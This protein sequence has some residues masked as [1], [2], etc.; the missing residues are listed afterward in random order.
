MHK[1]SV[2]IPVYQVEKYIRETVNSVLD[3]SY[4]NL[5]VILVDDGSFDGS[6]LICDEFEKK[7]DRVKVIHKENGGLSDARNA[8][9]KCA[10]GDFVLF[11]DG[12]DYWDDPYAIEKLVKRLNESK[13]DVLNYSYKK[14]YEDTGEE[15]PYF[16]HLEAMPLS[17]KSKYE[18]IDY[19]T[20][21]HLYI[22]SACNK[23]IKRELFDGEL[24]FR[25]GVYSEDIEWCLKLMLKAESMDFICENFYCYRQRSDSI[26]KTINNK[27][28]EDLC[29]NILR[30]FDLCKDIDPLLKEYAYR[31][32]AY[33]YGTF[34]KNQ[35][36]SEHKADECIEKLKP[37][38]WILKYHCNNKKLMGLN[39]VSKIFGFKRTCNM[40]RWIYHLHS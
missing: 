14:C 30:C 8:G 1:I 18:R 40:I 31:Y 12:D 23:L 36:I 10:S 39:I 9:I 38:S 13:A 28:C 26:S 3:Q 32:I 22:A 4:G 7:D 11:L 34:Y 17:L 5:E 37:Y 27:K 24:L 33:Q 19:L 2:I 15:I 21:N 35:A 20:K 29:N 6:P 16:D 25:K